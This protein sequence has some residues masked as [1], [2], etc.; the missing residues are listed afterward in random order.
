MT[1]ADVS[2]AQRVADRL[3]RLVA[4]DAR[5]L[6]A[7]SGGP[8]SLAL[9]DLVAA[10]S[11]GRSLVV[12]HVDHGIDPATAAVAATVRAEASARGLPFLQRDVALGAGATETRARDAR[13]KAL[14]V[15]AR[16]AGADCIL[17]A[18]HAD[19]QA[20]TVLL[21]L[22]RGSGPAGLSGMAWRRGRWVR[23]LLHVRRAELAGH[24][25]ARGIAAWADPA[26]VDPRHLRSWLRTA[27]LPALRERLPDVD[28]RLHTAA[29]HA[30]GARQAWS[31]LLPL[32]PSLGLQRSD[33]GISVA[34]PVS[35]EYRSALR[36]AILAAIGREIGVVLGAR[37][38][39]AIDRLLAASESGSRAIA[40]GG[41]VTVELAFGRLTFYRAQVADVT[42]QA[43]LPGMLVQLHGAAFRVTPGAGDERA[44][45]GWR[46]A[47][48]PGRYLV[49]SWR[50][51][52]R[53][54]PLGGV[55][56]RAVAVL[57]REARVPPMRRRQWPV[58]IAG[59]DATIVWVPGICRSD[60]ALPADGTEAWCVE[61][62]L[63]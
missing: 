50:E 22:L 63:A 43:L 36:H 45:G 5:C 27:I 26:N 53:I 16:E 39:A 52:D 35:G 18:H 31:E 47:V 44:R 49:R 7:V 41:G 56:S 12:G 11:G 61:C 46:A 23:P 6:V 25:A 21:R 1:G 37:R 9:L 15:M 13:R 54:R 55:G 10:H 24:L 42:E 59:D 2:L 62:T 17:L 33:R 14:L 28:E 60:A 32:L 34:A 38:L 19:D 3:D 57:L 29:R 58:V 4:P 51:G 8:D 48:V 30:A 20:E 40:I